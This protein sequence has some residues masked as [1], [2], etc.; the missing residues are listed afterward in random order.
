MVNH[1]I[2]IRSRHDCKTNSMSWVLL[3][4]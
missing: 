2:R 1:S 4:I 3:T